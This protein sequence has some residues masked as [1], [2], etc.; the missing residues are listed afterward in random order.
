MGK[1]FDL[2]KVAERKNKTL[3]ECKS[4]SFSKKSSIA[5]ERKP[6]QT[7]NSLKGD[8]IKNFKYYTSI[9]INKIF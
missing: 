7:N 8:K 5:I 3:R 6:R 1:S 4:N 2:T 9:F